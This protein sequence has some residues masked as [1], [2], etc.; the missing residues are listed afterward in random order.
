MALHSDSCAWPREAEA[1]ASA[2]SGTS[3][4]QQVWTV[5]E[6]AFEKNGGRNG[7]F[8]SH[9]G[10]PSL[11]PFV[12]GFPQKKNINFWATPMQIEP[13][14]SLAWESLSS[15]FAPHRTGNI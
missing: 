12:E 9:G 7:A 8:L 11:H 4:R 13:H 1:E 5:P 15:S 2:T 10:T 14:L 6:F 3:W